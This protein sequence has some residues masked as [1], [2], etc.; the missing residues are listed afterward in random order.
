MQEWKRT[1]GKRKDIEYFT[2]TIDPD[3]IA[4]VRR[5]RSSKWALSFAG[6]SI[7]CIAIIVVA[8][9]M[10]VMSKLL[11]ETIE[12]N[13]RLESMLQENV[14]AQAQLEDVEKRVEVLEEKRE[15]IE[16]MQRNILYVFE[17]LSELNVPF[18]FDSSAFNITHEPIALY[19]DDGMDVLMEL[20]FVLEQRVIQM[21]V[22]S[23]YADMLSVFW[24]YRPSGWPIE[25]R[26][27][28]SEFGPRSW[29]GRTEDHQGIDIRSPIGAE[30]TAT[31]NGIVTTA[32]WDG[33]YGYTVVIEHGDSGYS[34][35]YAHNSRVLV[36]VGERVLRG[37]I[38]AL[39]GNTGQ[40]TGP[41]LH[42]EVRF[43][44]IPQDP[45]KYLE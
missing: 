34:T 19:Q 37:Q 7:L 1:R 11:S 27:I 17:E 39:S 38:I 18:T 32:G 9:Q 26:E 35:L 24:G 13:Y 28:S 42:Y 12:E 29:G 6:A 8:F 2:I 23:D 41:H 22:L 3:S 4:K 45:M 33:A 5:I 16:E 10:R 36:E 31:A 25:A 43:H 44:D 21:Q 20:Y 15:S 30:I 14:S 40:T